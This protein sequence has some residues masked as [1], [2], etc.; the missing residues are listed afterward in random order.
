M[1]KPFSSRAILLIASAVLTL[2]SA[3][4]SG[5]SIKSSTQSQSD[6]TPAST[7]GAI[8]SLPTDPSPVVIAEPTPPPT[9]QT[10]PFEFALDR[11]ASA[12]SIGASAQSQDD[13]KL[14]VSQWQDAIAL[15]KQVPNSSPYQLL[16]KEKISEYQQQLAY[17]KQQASKPDGSN[18]PQPERII[19]L[20]PPPIPQPVEAA[21]SNVATR[22]APPAPRQERVF[23]APIK[24][25]EGGTPVIDVT[26]NGNQ[27]FEMIVDTGASGTLITQQMAIAMGVK[28]V[29]KALV[30]TASQKGVEIPVGFVDSIEVDGAVARNVSVA[31]AG[32]DLGTGLLGHDFFGNFDVTIRRD[33]VEFRVR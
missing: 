17:A 32:P 33:V 20:A 29:T 16:V 2:V 1:P 14:V 31:I 22:P 4:C 28:P 12:A 3:A 8:A 18:Q 5:S 11:A 25:R 10:D 15:L 6:S 24:R 21:R 7:S 27:T 19:A 23:E 26:F 13:W 30:D 9:P